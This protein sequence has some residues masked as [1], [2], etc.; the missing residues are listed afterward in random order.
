[1]AQG[2]GFSN[3]TCAVVENLN[4]DLILG[5]DVVEKLNDK[6][7]EEQ[8]DINKVINLPGGNP[9]SVSG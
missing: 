3:I 6:I 4:Y 2:K 7:N 8:F 9:E 1:M 5:S